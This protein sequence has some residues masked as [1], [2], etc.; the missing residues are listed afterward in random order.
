MAAPPSKKLD[1]DRTLGKTAGAFSVVFS[2][3]LL[4]LK[5]WA[6]Y[7]TGSEAVFSDALE[8]VVNVVAAAFALMVIY[9]SA[10]PADESHPYG[11][12]KAEFFSAGFEGGLVALGGAV[13]IA[14]ALSALFIGFELQNI[15]QGLY[16]TAL[17]GFLNLGLG[18]GLIKVGKNIHS[19]ALIASGHHAA[20]D[21]WT[22]AVVVAGLGMVSLTGVKLLDPMCAL[23]V[24][25]YLTVTGSKI[26]RK[27]MAGLL[28][29][30]ETPH[31]EKLV[32]ALE[33][34][35]EA[36]IIQAHHTRVIRSG[37]YHHIDM[38]IVVPEFWN[39]KYA[40]DCTEDYESKVIRQYPHDGEIHFH[41]DPCRQRYCK[42]CDIAECPIRL[43]EFR[44][45]RPFALA[46]LVSPTEPGQRGKT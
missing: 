13:I 19:D 9:Y 21:F 15:S 3:A 20:S 8:S 27:S 22:S 46:D 18:L 37:P 40:H 26:L 34:N 1:R 41:I 45:R 42:S 35:R 16:L 44:S 28:D 17:A 2:A 10:R 7:L 24:G 39:V 43:E 31:L 29:E 30:T 14:K 36:G 32:E 23:G 5:F 33:E 4:G 38:H 6:Y 12:G 11:H 25:L